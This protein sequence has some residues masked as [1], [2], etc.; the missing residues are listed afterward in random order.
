M[1]R[2]K[3]RSIA[4]EILERVEKDNAYVNILF[5]RLAKTNELTPEEFPVVQRMVRGVLERRNSLDSCIDARLS[6]RKGGIPPFV[7]NVL[8]IAAYQLLYLDRV[9]QHAVVNESVT[10]VKA[11]PYGRLGGLANAV[12]RRIIRECCNGETGAAEEQGQAAELNHPE[13]MIRRWQEQFG[14]EETARICRANNAPWPLYIRINTL[15]TTAE[16][17]REALAEE[18]VGVSSAEYAADCLAINDLPA[19]R[20]IQELEAFKRGLFFVQD[21]SSVLVTQLLSAKPGETVIDLCSA[22]GGKASAMAMQM[23]NTGRLIA[24]ELNEKRLRLLRENAERLG[25]TN[26]ELAAADGRTFV[27]PPGR[28]GT[29]ADLFDADAVLVDA[30]CS[31]L[32]VLGRHADARWNKKEEDIQ[33]LLPIQRDLLAHAARLVKPG[34]RLVYSTC[35]IEPAENEDVVENFLSQHP[36]FTAV[37]AAGLL[38]SKVVSEK[39]CLRTWPH[40]H[41]SAGGFAALLRKEAAI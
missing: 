23:K 10:V 15:R 21:Q 8:R 9:P 29:A 20:R 37:N 22:P 36:E 19:N 14:T 35:T 38:S 1:V 40:R 13:W 31:G 17:L 26:L 30:P 7:R 16:R 5:D 32:G 6:G 34:G 3:V 33:G 11:G 28:E 2:A 18:G 4:A 41:R 39:G 24:V 27:P 25:L 12:L